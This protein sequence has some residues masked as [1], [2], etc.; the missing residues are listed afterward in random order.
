[1]EHLVRSC[2]KQGG[3]VFAKKAEAITQKYG[4]A[5]VA[6]LASNENPYPPS[7]LAVSAAERELNGSNR[8]PDERVDV[9]TQALTSCYGSGHFL[10]GVGMYAC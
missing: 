7:G 10:T 5:R 2:Y 4:V 1:M 3:Y 6:R 8:Y 9:L